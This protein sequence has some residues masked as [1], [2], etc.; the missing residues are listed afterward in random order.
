MTRLICFS[1][2]D[3]ELEFLNGCPYAFEGFLF[4]QCQGFVSCDS[5]YFPLQ[6]PHLVISETLESNARHMFNRFD[7]EGKSYTGFTGVIQ[8]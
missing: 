3:K 4:T 6:E 7:P 1:D 2:S 8:S 5:A